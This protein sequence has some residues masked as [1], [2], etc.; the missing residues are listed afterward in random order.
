MISQLLSSAGFSLP[1]KSL[2]ASALG[3]LLDFF[4]TGWCYCLSPCPGG[5][6]M[7][8]QPPGVSGRLSGWAGLEAMP[9]NQVEPWNWAPW[10]GWPNGQGDTPGRTDCLDPWPHRSLTQPPYECFWDLL[11][12]SLPA[13]AWASNIHALIAVSSLSHLHLLPL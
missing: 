12:A 13:G 2:Y 8:T 11:W 10:P 7:Y 1:L 4:R 5:H 3:F 9:S 6:R